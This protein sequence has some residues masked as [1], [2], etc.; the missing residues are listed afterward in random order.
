[1]SELSNLREAIVRLGWD[2]EADPFVELPEAAARDALDAEGD[3]LR[4]LHALADAGNIPARELQ[5]QLDTLKQDLGDTQN[6]LDEQ[7][8]KADRYESNVDQMWQRFQREHLAN[9]HPAPVL[10]EWSDYWLR[11]WWAPPPSPV[12]EPVEIS[13]SPDDTFVQVAAK[14]RAALDAQIDGRCA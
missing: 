4:G 10:Y 13:L 14:V 8:A 6:E 5:E 9:V 1:M 3:L 7:Q 2:G 12:R 11:L